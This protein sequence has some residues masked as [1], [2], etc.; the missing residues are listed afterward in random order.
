MPNILICKRCAEE[1][2]RLFEGYRSEIAWRSFLLCTFC[3]LV[4]VYCICKIMKSAFRIVLNYVTTFYVQHCAVAHFVLKLWFVYDCT[5]VADMNK[6]YATNTTRAMCVKIMWKGC[7][8]RVK[9]R[10]HVKS[11]LAKIKVHHIS[12]S[13]ACKLFD[14]R[15]KFCNTCEKFLWY[16][17]T[18][19]S[20]QFITC[21]IFSHMWNN[22]VMHVNFKFHMHNR[23][24]V[25]EILH[26]HVNTF[27]HVR[28]TMWI[29]F[30]AC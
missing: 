24:Y 26:M 20:M 29:F 8:K 3:I 18:F 4:T 10:N 15:V 23:C 21:E 6:L 19:F 14:M 11:M 13:H 7:E 22:F 28:V 1:H 27:R 2:N 30:R 17:W 5:Y 12:I 16:V 9:K 25:C